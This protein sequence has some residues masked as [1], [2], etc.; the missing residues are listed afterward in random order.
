MKRA[1]LY[2]RTSTLSLHTPETLND[3]RQTATLRGYQIVKQYTDRTS[4]NKA[5]HPQL[6]QLIS[7]ARLGCFD[8]IMVES[9]SD[10]AGSVRACLSVMD[11]L[12]QIG[13]GFVSCRE[14]IDTSDT[15]M[16]QAM[17]VIVRGLVE[18]E[19]TLRIANV[20]AG[21][22]RSKLEGVHIGRTPLAVDRTAIVRDRASGLSLTDVSKKHGIS[23]AMV[24]RL[25]KLANGQP[26]SL[27]PRAG[28]PFTLAESA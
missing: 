22:R 18:L 2:L 5:K 23:R 1:A 24:C 16:G 17:G 4:G 8:V 13:I 12:N 3:F 11:Q 19:R 25:V 28:A 27:P 6:D 21:M 20:K 10:V 26:Y 15:S 14:G 7:D 9:L